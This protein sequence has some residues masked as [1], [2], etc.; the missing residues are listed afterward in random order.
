MAV[1]DEFSINPPDAK[2]SARDVRRQMLLAEL[3]QG[4]ALQLRRPA[5]HLM[6]APALD[7]GSNIEALWIAVEALWEHHKDQREIVARLLP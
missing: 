3:L 4:P 7:S 1:Q 5:E 6:R 2:P